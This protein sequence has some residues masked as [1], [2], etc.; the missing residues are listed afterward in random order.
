[1]RYVDIFIELIRLAEQAG[2]VVKA[3]MSEKGTCWVEVKDLDDNVYSFAMRK[4][5]K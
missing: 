1:M 4:E 3:G 2:T 5:E